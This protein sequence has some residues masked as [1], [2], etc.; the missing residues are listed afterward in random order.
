[1]KSFVL[2]DETV[3]THGFRLLTSGANLTEF[4]KNPV[5]LLNHNDWSM[6]IG[7]WENIR[8]EGTQIL[9][10]P[11]FDENDP[12]GAQVKSKV[13]NDFVRAASIGA[14]P[15]EQMVDDP[16]L[17]VPGQTGPTVTRWTIREASIVTIPANHNS[18]AF[19]DRTT[20]KMVDSGE[21]LKLFDLITKTLKKEPEMKSLLTLLKL[22]DTATEAEAHA[23]MQL[24]MN[25]RDRLKAE[26][27]TLTARIDELNT[28]DK[29]RKKAE[30]VALV[31]AA[32]KDGRIDAKAKES[33]LLLFDQNYE[34]AKTALDAIA[35]RESV[36]GRM[37]AKQGA[38]NL[39]YADLQKKSWEELDKAG[40]LVLLR[41]K[42]PDLYDEKFEKRFGTKPK[43][44]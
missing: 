43:K 31:D 20:G 27:V 8:V 23:A 10:D 37:Q 5:M 36:A 38:D 21:V 17:R 29:A 42:Y 1:M 14:W 22:A 7:R 9:A 24:V 18:I 3:N 6:P 25:D 44:S 19:Y 39:E 28:A 40:H 15:P 11:V 41:D 16:A 2:H 12:V 4:R 34:A 26:N 30:A 32:V 35:K 13:D 33:Y